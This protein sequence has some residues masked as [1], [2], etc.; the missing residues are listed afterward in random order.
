M[1]DSPRTKMSAHKDQPR[2]RERKATRSPV[3]AYNYLINFARKGRGV[4]RYPKFEPLDI[5]GN[6]RVLVLAPHPDDGSLGCGGTIKLIEEGWF[7]QRISDFAY[8]TAK[9]KASGEKPVIGVNPSR[10][11]ATISSAERKVLRPLES[12]GLT[13]SVSPT[14]SI[15][16]ERLDSQAFT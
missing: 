13:T 3:E 14:F 15:R 7:Q 9:R 10:R 6:P 16:T 8:E 12:H 4:F 11:E 2:S 5:S 1:R